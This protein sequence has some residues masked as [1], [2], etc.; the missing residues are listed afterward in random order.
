[1]N[2]CYLFLVFSFA[3]F[4]GEIQAQEQRAWQPDAVGYQ[5]VVVPFFRSYCNPC[6]T[7]EKP[8]ADFALDKRLPNDFFD[9][10][11]RN[12][13][14]EIVNV[15]NSHEM[16]PAKSIQPPA[17]DT[18]KVV[19]WITAQTVK[20]ELERRERSVV[21]RRLNRD[22]YRN[23]IRDLVGL[24]FDISA[25]PQ[26]PP[27]GGFDN[28]GGALTIS[29][30]HLETYLNAARQILDRALV[31]GS[32]PEKI[33]WKFAPRVG[34]IDRTRLRLDAKNNAIVNGGNNRQEGDFV[35]IHRNEWDKV[36]GARDFAVPHPGMYSIRVSAAGRI[37]TRE[38]TIKS[39]EAMLA[40][41]R[42]D[43]DSKNPRG[44]QWT[45][46][47]YEYDLEHFR[48]NPMY[49]YGPPRIKLILQLG[50][51]P[52]T[53][54]EFDVDALAG[55]PEIYEFSARF[56]TERAGVGLEYA[57]SI[58]PVLENFWMQRN[59]RFARPELMIDWFEIEGPM[60]DSW[61]P[62]S[63]QKVLFRSDLQKSAPHRYVHEVLTK[64]MRQAYRR[65]VSKTEV[66]AKL[67]LFEAAQKDGLSFV[68]AVKRP[69]IAIL[70]SPNF[71]FLVEPAA[72]EASNPTT[73][74]D[75]ALAARLSYFLWSTTP[76]ETLQKL[77]DAGQL[78]SR[79][80]RLKQV[81][82]MLMDPRTEAFVKNFAGQ[83]LGLREVGTNPP[84]A[85]LF[86]QYDR[87]LETSIVRESEAF[88]QEVLKQNLDVRNLVKSDFV[89][90]NERLGRFY[91]IPAVV[92]DH[93]RR[94]TVPAGI[95]RG[96]IVTQ[97]SILTITSNGTRTSPVK[98]GTW[99]MKTL[100]GIDPG[101]PVANAGEIAPKVPG[102]DR[103]TVRKRLEIHRELE[104]CARCH[105]KI[106]PLGFALENYNAAGEW[107]DFEG[108]GYKGRV[109]DGDPQIDASSQMIDGKR[110]NGVHGLQQAILDKENL[111]LGCLASKLLTYALGRELGLA[112]QPTIQAAVVHM[113][114]NGR[115]LKS[116]IQFIAT[117]ESFETK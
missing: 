113:Q 15:L 12:N 2:H 28:N 90:I 79:E 26:D 23:T 99:V 93:F 66:D 111:F 69:L 72:N 56:T 16:P 85:D 100:L 82:R 97:A 70:T 60:F 95:N 68:E 71:L 103:A 54:A 11:A 73:L 18:T 102:I 27:A 6:H 5:K 25:F 58:P 98:R 10:A 74:S 9:P 107:R 64:F 41:R 116:V 115:T 77:A 76:D 22:E 91:D 3:A 17:S 67:K 63:H 50:S 53:I 13:W 7:G 20:A 30:L 48:T 51:Q 65:P 105:N 55:K 78:H 106:D 31:E 36:I 110:I 96:G 39:A 108:F 52:R 89:V 24:D 109:Q 35:V 4:T 114:K 94:V 117:S 88:F 62:T 42:D 34:P 19:E 84:A 86:P 14:A 43:Q 38:E 101:L 40:W 59:D 112:D 80:S 92:G 87:H 104:Q 32:Q 46:R 44:K 83:W 1:M 81:D 37:P 33:R 29:P 61:P 57:Y 49:N 75:H 47:Q 21:L 8:K 45:Q